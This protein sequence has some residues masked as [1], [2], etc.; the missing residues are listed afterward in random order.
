[1]IFYIVVL[2]L[3]VVHFE[4][5]AFLFLVLLLI[6]WCVW[7]RKIFICRTPI[8]V[9]LG[10][11]VLWVSLTIPF[12]SF[13]VYSLQEF[14]KL[15]KQVIIF[16]ATLYFFQDRTR[17][18]FLVRLIIG[19]GLLVCTYGLLHYET[20]NYRSMTSFLPAE[21]WLVTYLVMILPLCAMLMFYDDGPW[22]KGVYAIGVLLICGCLVLTQSRAGALAFFVQL[23]VGVALIKRRALTIVAGAISILAVIFTIYT[24][25]V[26]TSPDGSWTLQSKGGVKSLDA[27]SLLHR[28]EIWT[29]T[30][31]RISEHPI[32]GIGFG[33]QT[34]RW[35]FGEQPDE[36]NS[37]P[38]RKHGTHNILLELALHTG[39]LGMM[40]FIWLIVRLVKTIITES[41][42]ASDAF[43]RGVLL[44]IGLGIIG[45]MVRLMFDQMLVG[46][47][48][49]Q[50]W[51]LAAAAML[52][53][54]SYCFFP[55]RGA[56]ED[57]SSVMQF[58]R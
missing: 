5:I 46:V 38:V 35:L 57:G 50:F 18:V 39:V 22:A 34:S 7:N 20:G 53:G 8:N 48:A 3:T 16:Y 55:K 49:V 40:L 27:E 29:F 11:F 6:V 44:G 43:S 12:A 21:V 4:R 14:G 10:L 15:I 23:W 31:A 41:R 19:T 26:V 42:Q 28:K 32:V 56:V 1:M 51:V 13:P 9:P 37:L 58:N 33:K 24:V 25:N 54:K 47:L 45:L 52:A 17:M 2:P 30:I 36:K